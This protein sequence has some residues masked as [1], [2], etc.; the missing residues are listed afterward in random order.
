MRLVTAVA[1]V[2]AVLW[3]H[4]WLRIL[5]IHTS[6]AVAIGDSCIITLTKLCDT[7]QVLI[8]KIHVQ[9][10]LMLNLSFQ[11]VDLLLVLVTLRLEIAKLAS[12]LVDELLLL[13]TD[14]LRSFE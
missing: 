4:Y 9:A 14:L 1:H 5:S 11:L 3:H 6:S 10:F 13:S 7:C 2:S 8:A 12:L